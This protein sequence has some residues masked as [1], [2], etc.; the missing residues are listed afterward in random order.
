MKLLQQLSRNQTVGRVN[1][2]LGAL[3]K[4]LLW[5]LYFKNPRE[6][7]SRSRI[8]LIS[9]KYVFTCVFV[10]RLLAKQKTIQT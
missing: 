8:F 9:L 1:S 4:G 3:A 2:Q 10:S 5:A 6:A 7:S